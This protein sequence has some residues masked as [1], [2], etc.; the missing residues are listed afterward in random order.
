MWEPLQRLQEAEKKKIKVNK[1]LACKEVLYLGDIIKSRHRR[2][3]AKAGETKA[4]CSFTARLGILAWLSSLAQIEELNGKLTN[5]QYLQ[6][7]STDL[8]YR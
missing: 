2:G 6:H 3:D 8:I 5:I 4:P 7:F 1:N